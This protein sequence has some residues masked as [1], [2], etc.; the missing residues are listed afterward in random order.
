MKKITF[1]MV[2]APA[3]IPVKPKIAAIMA[4]IRKITVHFNIGYV[5]KVS[6]V[7]SGFIKRAKPISYD[8]VLRN[9]LACICLYIFTTFKKAR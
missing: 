4:M 2:A 7:F 9:G 8:V 3:A 5:L 1:A 6:N